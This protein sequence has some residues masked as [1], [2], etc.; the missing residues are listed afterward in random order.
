MLAGLHCVIV[1][2]YYKEE[3]RLCEKLYLVILFR[4]SGSPQTARGLPLPDLKLQYRGSFSKS[5]KA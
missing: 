5:S 3:A 1:S 4:G 2:S